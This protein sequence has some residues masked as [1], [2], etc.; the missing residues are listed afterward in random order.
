MCRQPVAYRVEGQV[1]ADIQVD[2]ALGESIG[3]LVV[4]DHLWPQLSDTH[5]LQ[6]TCDMH[7]KHT[8]C[9]NAG[10]P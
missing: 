3:L 2:G 6:S 1:R 9:M 8:L 5:W 4:Q 10:Q 7:P